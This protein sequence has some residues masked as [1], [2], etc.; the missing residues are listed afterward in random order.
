MKTVNETNEQYI[1][2]KE[3]KS[4]L[5]VLQEVCKRNKAAYV[6]FVM[7]AEPP[8]IIRFGN[9]TEQGADFAALLLKL[10]EIADEKEAIGNVVK[11]PLGKDLTN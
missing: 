4:A 2:R 11:D 5:E 10:T 9:V 6:G 3:I 1:A 8:L 7:S